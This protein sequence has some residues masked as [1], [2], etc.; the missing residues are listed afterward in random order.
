MKRGL[1]VVLL[2]SL[3]LNLGLAWRVAHRG[4]APAPPAME[5]GFV[6]PGPGPEGGE[7]G[8]VGPDPRQMAHRR[9]ARLTRDLD[10]T[11]AQQEA[12]AEI[13]SK[14]A[15]AFVSRRTSIT[16]QRR[17]LRDAYMAGYDR[18]RCRDG[19]AEAP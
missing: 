10:L 4:A 14:A 5:P 11:P 7:S 9:L 19:G 1:L 17:A 6:P 15:D 8:E 16:Q 3:G 13:H 12:F 18:P 2:L